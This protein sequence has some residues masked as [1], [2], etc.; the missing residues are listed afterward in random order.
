MVAPD[1]R[2]PGG[3]PEEGSRQW[4]AGFWLLE[5]RQGRRQMRRQDAG[6]EVEGEA[7]AGDRSGGGG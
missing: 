7:E 1:S 5:Q 4:G 6:V 3:C 2:R